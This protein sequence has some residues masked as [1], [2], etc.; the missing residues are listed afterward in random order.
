MVHHMKNVGNVLWYSKIHNVGL[1]VSLF[2]E[3]LI[4]LIKNIWAEWY[5]TITVSIL[6]DLVALFV[7]INGPNVSWSCRSI[8]E[9]SFFYCYYYLYH[10]LYYKHIL[11]SVLQDKNICWFNL[12]EGVMFHWYQFFVLYKQKNASTKKKHLYRTYMLLYK[13][14]IMYI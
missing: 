11:L 1:L 6:W 8:V 2:H 4:Y 14:L 13:C 10:C 7:H 5:I 3:S 12:K 9:E